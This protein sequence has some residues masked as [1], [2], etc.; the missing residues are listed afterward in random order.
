[1]LRLNTPSRLLDRKLISQLTN[2][3]LKWCKNTYGENP[4]KLNLRWKIIK[5]DNES[6]VYGIYVVNDHRIEIY[7]NHMDRVSDI[8]LTCIHEYTH[9]LQQPFRSKYLRV[10]YSRNIYQKNA[11][12]IAQRDLYKCWKDIRTN[13]I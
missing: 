3:T 2:D 12:R 5:N 10:A 1:M 7:W 9:Y 4:S 13:F 6:D 8:L 11:E